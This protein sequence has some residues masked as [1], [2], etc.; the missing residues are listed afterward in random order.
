MVAV[1]NPRKKFTLSMLRN[2][3]TI[4]RKTR[5]GGGNFNTVESSEDAKQTLQKRAQHR[6]QAMSN[7]NKQNARVLPASPRWILA[8]KLNEGLE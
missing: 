7:L 4:S 1:D 3:I 8:A 2:T 6:Q 5:E